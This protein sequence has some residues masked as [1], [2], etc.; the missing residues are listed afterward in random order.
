[1]R[2]CEGSFWS[3]CR[4][5]CITMPN[6]LRARSLQRET[7]GGD[8]YAQTADWICILLSMRSS[9]H[10]PSLQALLHERLSDHPDMSAK[11]YVAAWLC[12]TLMEPFLSVRDCREC[13]AAVFGQCIGH[14]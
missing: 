6:A 8:A 1:M 9:G 4:R 14:G 12:R 10:L 2:L 3:G 5:P 7:V 13:F 11:A